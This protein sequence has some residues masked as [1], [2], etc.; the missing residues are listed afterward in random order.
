MGIAAWLIAWACEAL[1]GIEGKGAQAVQLFSAGILSGYRF[2]VGSE[3]N[4]N[5]WSRYCFRMMKRRFHRG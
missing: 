2:Y 5:A 1:F 4:E 3:V